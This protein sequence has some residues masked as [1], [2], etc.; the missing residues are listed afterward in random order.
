MALKPCRECKKKVSTQAATCPNCGAPKPTLSEIP[1][2]DDVLSKGVKT[3]SEGVENF[4]KGFYGKDY[5]EPKKKTSSNDGNIFGFWGGGEGLAKTFWL[6]FIGGN[7]FITILML[8]AASEGKGMVMFVQIVRIIWMI[9][10]TIGVFNAA[11]IY[12]NEKIKLGQSYGYATAAKIFT[13]VI[14]LSAIGNAL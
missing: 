10:A 13:V 12:K 6:Y 14:I 9:F 7:M 1:S 4:K 8:L 2:N 11:D 5:V 3:I